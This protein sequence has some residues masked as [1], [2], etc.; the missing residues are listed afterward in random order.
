MPKARPLPP[1]EARPITELPF[2]ALKKANGGHFDPVAS[3][4]YAAVD[5]A[6]GRPAGMGRGLYQ[7]T[8]GPVEASVNLS[9]GVTTVATSAAP[10]PALRW[11]V[12]AEAPPSKYRVPPDTDF[13]VDLTSRYE[14]LAWSIEFLPESGDQRA[15]EMNSAIGILRDVGQEYRLAVRQLLQDGAVRLYARMSSTSG[16]EDV[17]PDAVPGCC[18]DWPT[19]RLLLSDG[20]TAEQAVFTP[21]L[22]RARRITGDGP[23]QEDDA[24][25][26][27]RIGQ[28]ILE[29][30][31]ERAWRKSAAI[32]LMRELAP[33]LSERVCQTIFAELKSALPKA[34]PWWKGGR[35]PTR[36]LRDAVRPALVARGL[37]E[38]GA[39]SDD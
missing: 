10:Q 5:N 27:R 11:L 4:L 34:S 9:T 33:S 13:D 23:P 32:S 29:A 2:F 39:G 6:G 20:R 22:G 28:A 3:R 24:Q 25:L 37:V 30:S 14:S 12:P 31:P 38:D 8:I 21:A 17:Y 15:Y 35:P 1:A 7:F 18:L 16:F 26:C 19:M 36:P